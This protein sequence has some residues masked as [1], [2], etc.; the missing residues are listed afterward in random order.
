MAGKNQDVINISH[1]PTGVYLVK[2]NTSKGEILK[3]VVK[4]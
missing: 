1:L 4:E 3:K 2:M